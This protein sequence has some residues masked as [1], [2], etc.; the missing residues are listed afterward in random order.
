MAYIVNAADFPLLRIVYEGDTTEAEMRV[1]LEAYD[2]VIARRQRY[3][4]LLDASRA[5]VPSATIR[6]LKADFLRERAG[7]LGALCVGGAFVLASPAIRGAM[8]AIFWLQ[9]LPY[10]HVVV[11][12]VAEGERWCRERVKADGLA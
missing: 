12:S 5:A 3:A 1:Y 7:V 11:G 8:S 10:P 9:P 4:L 6:Q 2:A